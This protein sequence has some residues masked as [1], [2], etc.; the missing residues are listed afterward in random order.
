VSAG[1]GRGRRA[2]GAGA[3]VLCALTLI[4]ACG[5]PGRPLWWPKARHTGAQAGAAGRRLGPH[6]TASP[7]PQVADPWTPGQPQLGIDV[8]WI[9][10][11][12]D[13]AAV[14]AAKARRIINYAISLDAN[15]I[16]LSFPFYTYGI[17]SDTLY[18]DR[19]T[20]PSPADIGI[21]LAAAAASHIRV[22]LRPL[23][24]EA[25]LIAQNPIAWRGSI[26][27][28]DPSAWFASYRELLLRYASV[29]QAGHAAT[30]VIG[31]E[32]DSLQGDPRWP[33]LIRSVRAAFHGELLYD[34]NYLD[35]QDHDADLP[36]STFGV[37]AYPRFGGL[38]DSATVG[39]LASAW[40]GWLGGHRASVLKAMVLSEVGIAAVSGAYKIPGDWT[41]TTTSPIVPQIQTRWYKAVC[42]AFAAEHI[43]G[44]YWWEI[45]F[46]A[47]PADPAPFQT[48]RLT[49]LGR[50]AQ[51][52]IRACFAGFSPPA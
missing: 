40:E 45:S 16:G 51:Q 39:E 35:F 21:F 15:S 43:A 49:F 26:E 6:P 8:Y 14:V 48:D 22:T 9:G 30:F 11:P 31:T 44:L 17:T 23:L 1:P 29:A 41:Q 24:N 42:R 7:V 38:D 47:N 5:I 34:E 52:E 28:A 20:T 3:A 36:L 32:L 46:D 18:A 25:A 12:R 37:D 2:L 10:N 27:P 4:S 13:S 33:G 19:K 50:P